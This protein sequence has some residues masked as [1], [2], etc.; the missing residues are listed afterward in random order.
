MNLSPRHEGHPAVNGQRAELSTRS[1]LQPMDHLVPTT[2]GSA[3][4]SCPKVPVQAYF[5]KS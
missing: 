1:T 2:Q 5:T 3:P 4:S